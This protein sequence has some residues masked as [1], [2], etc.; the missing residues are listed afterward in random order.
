MKTELKRRSRS[1]NHFNTRDWNSSWRQHI[2]NFITS[3]AQCRCSYLIFFPQFSD[4]LFKVADGLFLR[5]LWW[6]NEA[7]IY[8]ALFLPCLGSWDE[9]L[10][11]CLLLNFRTNKPRTDYARMQ[12]LHVHKTSILLHGPPSTQS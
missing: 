6:E 1:M 11:I 9:N 3:T 2:F 12:Q 5:S 4:D 10:S 7:I 8:S